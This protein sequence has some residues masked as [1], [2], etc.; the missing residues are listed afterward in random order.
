ML[1]LPKVYGVLS[2]LYWHCYG[3]TS[4]VLSSIMPKDIF[5]WS[6]RFGIFLSSLLPMWLFDYP[7]SPFAHLYTINALLTENISTICNVIFGYGKIMNHPGH[8]TPVPFVNP[9]DSIVRDQHAAFQSN[10][11]RTSQM[12]IPSSV[13]LGPSTK[14]PEFIQPLI[15]KSVV[16][17]GKSTLFPYALLNERC[18]NPE[19]NKRIKAGGRIVIS[20]PRIIL[21]EK[22]NSPF[23][24]NRQKV[25]RATKQLHIPSDA[26]IILGTDGHILNRVLSEELTNQDIF[27]LDEFHE[28]NG[29]KIALFQHLCQIGALC[30]LLSATPKAVPGIE[31]GMMDASIPRRFAPTIW[32]IPDTLDP[33][34]ALRQFGGKFV[35]KWPM[36]GPSSPEAFRER[37]LIKCTHINGRGQANEV[38]EKLQYDRWSCYL[39]S[40]ANARDP[41]PDSAQVVVA[42][43][44]INTGLS[45]PGFKLMVT[46]GKMHAVHQGEHRLQWSDQDT[47]HQGDGRVGRYGP[48]D[49]VLRPVSAGT[50]ATPQAY[51]ST[52]YLQY[53]LNAKYHDLPQLIH[54]KMT[55][56]PQ[57]I[58]DQYEFFDFI[59]Y[60]AINKN[61]PTHLRPHLATYVAL[62]DAGLD[63]Q[64]ARTAYD[65]LTNGKETREELETII[66]VFTA[67]RSSAV[68]FGEIENA[69]MQ[70]RSFL[71]LM[72]RRTTKTLTPVATGLQW[73]SLEPFNEPP[74]LDEFFAVTSPQA[75]V[76]YKGT[77]RPLTE[78]G[79]KINT[80]LA[81]AKPATTLA[82]SYKKITENLQTEMSIFKTNIKT[83][84]DRALE[85][86]GRCT[87]SDGRNDR[88]VKSKRELRSAINSMTQFMYD[89]LNEQTQSALRRD[90]PMSDMPSDI[91]YTMDGDKQILISTRHSCDYCENIGQHVH[92]GRKTWDY[93]HLFVHPEVVI[94]NADYIKSENWEYHYQPLV[95]S[96][97]DNYAKD[98]PDSNLDNYDEMVSFSY[99][100]RNF[101]DVP[102][103]VGILMC[104]CGIH[105]QVGESG[106][107]YAVTQNMPCGCQSA[108]EGDHL[109]NP[110][111]RIL[112]RGSGWLARKPSLNV[113]II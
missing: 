41:I 12:E 45:L 32:P 65:N 16:A 94:D 18:H 42:T 36:T 103:D 93:E 87:T 97:Y 111:M 110:I 86:V 80:S 43:E 61:I 64:K 84:M 96:K 10:L 11:G 102:D 28:L 70:D 98:N 29:Q 40:G 92:V 6:K 107:N 5:I 74:K 44:V 14:T 3:D 78:T 72:C 46:D 60:I 79:H 7:I 54:Y 39:L 50:G 34:E 57:S 2:C 53:F 31:L 27:L 48:G 56:R 8:S 49:V 109:I 81:L 104:P 108:V 17:S 30:I 77:F 35:E 76:P 101:K 66:R 19:I 25:F 20:F 112:K 100:Y 9:W 62:I 82:E 68:P 23:E 22:W 88:T 24:N 95:R 105:I 55:V 38:L 83:R 99:D 113:R 67:I 21:R 47:Q 1:D 4:P 37:V 63:H 69:I 52:A 106:P 73:P 75:L 91:S 89:T 33:A 51:P 71:Y 26:Q 58:Q 85:S 90:L 59:P 15:V 13:S